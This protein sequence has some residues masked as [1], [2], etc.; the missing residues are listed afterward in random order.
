MMHIYDCQKSQAPDEDKHMLDLWYW[1]Q[2]PQLQV[3]SY[4]Q[5]ASAEVLDI[6]LQFVHF[7]N[8]EKVMDDCKILCAYFACTLCPKKTSLT[9]FF[10]N[11]LSDYDNFCYEYSRHQLPS[12]DRSV[13]HL[14]QCMLLH[15]PGKPDQANQ[16]LK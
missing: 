13:S 14:T 8:T 5:S 4:I 12:N 3:Q 15:Y 11:Q 16:V 7:L 10:Q 1:N 9:F 6:F 2:Y